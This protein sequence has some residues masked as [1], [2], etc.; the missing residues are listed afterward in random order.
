MTT[1]LRQHQAP[2]AAALAI[3][4][5]EPNSERRCERALDMLLTQRGDA[6]VVVEE[7]LADD[8]GC[9]CGHCLRAALIVRAESSRRARRLAQALP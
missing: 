5:V 9:V 1:T 7:L 8:P 4:V 6:S 2:D 3:G